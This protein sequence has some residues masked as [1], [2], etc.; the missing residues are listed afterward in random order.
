MNKAIYILGTKET[1]AINRYKIGRHK[2]SSKQLL[3]RYKTPLIN[4]KIYYF[5]STTNCIM[6]EKKIKNELGN[7]RILDEKGKRTEWVNMNLFE[8]KKYVSEIIH[9]NNLKNGEIFSVE[10]D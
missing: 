5:Q 6:V 2:G 3:A 9:E 8:L 10:L 1:A 4:P 7:Y